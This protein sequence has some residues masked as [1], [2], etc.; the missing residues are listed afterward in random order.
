MRLEAA[1]IKIGHS[2]MS[3]DCLYD[4]LSCIQTSDTQIFITSQVRK[5]SPYRGPVRGTP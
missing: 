4:N 1:K 5:C 3:N 2:R